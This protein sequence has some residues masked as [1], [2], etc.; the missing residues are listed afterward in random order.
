MTGSETE[1]V[2]ICF[3][4]SELKS[5]DVWA[6]ANGIGDRGEAIRR[7]IEQGLNVAAG[8]AGEQDIEAAPD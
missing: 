2:R 7:L 6:S 1:F 5:I 8:S 4:T 3:S